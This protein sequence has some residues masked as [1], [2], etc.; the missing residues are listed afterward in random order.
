MTNRMSIFAAVAAVVTLA[1]CSSFDGQKN[2]QEHAENY[3][4]LLD[5]RA[6]EVLSDGEPLTLQDC[7]EA[8]LKNNLDI[9]VAEVQQRVAQLGRKASFPSFSRRSI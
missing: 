4:Q 1:G 5:E 7:I 2:R 6:E 3:R 8:A 9:R